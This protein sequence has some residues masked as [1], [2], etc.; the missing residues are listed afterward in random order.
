[1]KNILFIQSSPRGSD[2]YSYQAA[3]SLVNELRGRGGHA[4]AANPGTRRA[5]ASPQVGASN[6]SAAASIKAMTCSRFTVGKPAR[7]SS[8][9]SPPS[10]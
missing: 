4:A 1:M 5:V 8:I 3:R 2:S 9:V 6:F 7:N 10:R